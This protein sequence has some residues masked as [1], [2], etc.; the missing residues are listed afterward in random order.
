MFCLLS[1]IQSL[2]EICEE[3]SVDLQTLDG[4]LKNFGVFFRKVGIFWG[5]LAFCAIPSC[6]NLIFGL[7]I[8]SQVGKLEKREESV[9]EFVGKVIC[10]LISLIYIYISSQFSVLLW[11]FEF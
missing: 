8:Q 4:I 9:E 2:D 11:D 10:K 3:F 7:V 1:K 6:Q 5:V